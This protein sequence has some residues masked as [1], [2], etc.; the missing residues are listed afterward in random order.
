MVRALRRADRYNPLRVYYPIV[1]GSKGP[2]D[3]LIHAKVMIIDNRFV[4][5]GSANLNNRSMGVDTECDLVVEATDEAE[6]KAVAQVRAQLLGEHLGIDPDDLNHAVDE[7]HG[8]LIHAIDSINR[9]ER[10]LRPYPE[11]DIDGATGFHLGTGLFD[12]RRPWSPV[13]WRGRRRMRRPVGARGRR[14]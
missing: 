14:H 4:R 11:I 12:P 13:W 7:H 2:C 10:G 1:P 8:S 6:G 9:G 5:I 3:V